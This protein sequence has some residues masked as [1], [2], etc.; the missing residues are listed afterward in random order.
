MTIALLGTQAFI[1]NAVLF[2]FSIVLVEFFSVGEAVAGVY[3]VPFA[4]VSA[5]GFAVLTVL[6]AGSSSG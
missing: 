5:V 2:T 6:F 3:L 4:L 1:Y